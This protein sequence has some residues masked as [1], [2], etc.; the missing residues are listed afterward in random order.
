MSD[1]TKKSTKELQKELV[2][3]KAELRDFR[4]SIAGARTGDV[5]EAR[6]LRKDVARIL[7]ELNSRR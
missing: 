4:F 1:I 2:E 3:K 5:K 7:T 6:N